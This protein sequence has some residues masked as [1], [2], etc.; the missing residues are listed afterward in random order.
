VVEFLGS[1]KMALDPVKSFVVDAAS[2]T[3]CMACE[4]ICPVKAVT[5]TDLPSVDQIACIGC[6]ACVSECPVQVFDLAHYTHD[7]VRATIESLMEGPSEDIRLLGLFGDVLAYVAA[8]SAG[9]ARLEYPTAIRIARLPSAARAARKEIL[10]AFAS[11]ADG[12][13]LSDEEGGEI[14]HIVE[15]RLGALAAELDE[16]GIGKERV[17]F[18]PMLLP[19]YKVLPKYIET[20]EKKIKQRGKLTAELREKALEASRKPY[21]PVFAKKS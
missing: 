13:A 11:G 18:I 3:K 21:D 9:T 1:G 19:V 20:F 2:C 17:T 4:N 14:A 5:V 8:D 16:I 12:V 10:L 6:G 15:E 7:Q